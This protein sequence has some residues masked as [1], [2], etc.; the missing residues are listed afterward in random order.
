MDENVSDLSRG[1]DREE[2]QFYVTINP[3]KVSWSQQVVS[4]QNL[5]YAKVAL[6]LG[7]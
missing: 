1:R 3:N 5:I 7:H 6:C 4:S 2:P